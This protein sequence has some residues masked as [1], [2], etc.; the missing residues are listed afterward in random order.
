VT[1][2]NR[3][4]VDAEETTSSSSINNVSSASSSDKEQN[5]Q[6][7]GITTKAFDNQPIESNDNNEQQL[8]TI[9]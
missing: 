9:S 7:D 1:A 5:Q 3:S 6:Q 2:V 8:L 4:A